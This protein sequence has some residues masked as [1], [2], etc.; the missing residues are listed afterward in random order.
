MPPG[1]LCSGREGFSLHA[2]MLVPQGARKR[3]EHL[4]R[5][6]ARPASATGRLSLA[7]RVA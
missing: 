4:C 7:Q 5:Q 3:L 6:V 1:S 2:Q